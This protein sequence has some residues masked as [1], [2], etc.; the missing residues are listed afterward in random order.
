MFEAE[1]TN[2]IRGPDFIARFMSGAVLDIGCGR[3]IA[4][5][6]A[7][8]FDKRHGDANYI[9]SQ[10]PAGSFDCVHSSHVLE[11]M[12]C[13]RQALAQ[14]WSL[15]KPGGYMVIVVPEEN[16]YEQGR[17]PSL[18]NSD[19][20][21]TFRIGGA[22]SWSPVSHDVGELVQTLPNC[23]VIELGLQDYG[24]DYSL[25]DD[26]RPISPAA[27][28]VSDLRKWIMQKLL[29]IGVPGMLHMECW[30][31]FIERRFGIPVD[32]TRLGAVAQIQVV[33]RKRDG[34]PP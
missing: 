34:H 19:H 30:F 33:L 10:L 22:E 3:D 9:G 5:P 32:Q 20:K 29:E 14:W 11:H 6:H 21:W 15:V 1:K 12:H 31:A 13:P 23:E 4:V 17:L 24:Y 26:V 27:R 28:A 18:F 8:P 2:R 16:I 25:I 7:R